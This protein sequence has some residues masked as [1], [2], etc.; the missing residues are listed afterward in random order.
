MFDKWLKLPAHYYLRITALVILTVGICLHNTL[1]SIGAIWIMANWLIEADYR[2]YWKK[3]KSTPTIWLLLGL[4]FL[5]LLSLLWSED[6]AYGLKD[7]GRKM[8]FF[9]I[10]F[11]LGLGKPVEKKVIFFLLYIFLGIVVLTSGINYYRYN[12]VLENV[13]DIRQMSYFISPIRFSVLTA[14][15]TFAA[16]YLIIKN[17]GPRI[18]WIAMIPWLLF[19]TFKAQM[20]NGYLMLAVLVI[21]TMIYLVKENSSYTW[22]WVIFSTFFF[23][24]VFGVWK[25]NSLVKLYYIEEDITLDDLELYTV[26]GNPYYHDLYTDVRENGNLV[27][28]YVQQEELSREWNERSEIPYDS[29]DRNGQPMYGT[30]MRYM[31]SKNLR[32]DSAGLAQLTPDEITKIENGATSIDIN[33][34]FRTKVFEVLYQWDMYQNGGDPNGHSLLQ[35]AEHMRVAWS[36]VKQHWL[37]GVGMGD[38]PT[39]FESEYSAT[40]SKLSEEY[41]HRSHNQYLTIWISHGFLGLICLVGMLLV[42]VFK[43]KHLDYFHGVVYLTLFFSLLFQDMIETQAGVTIFGLFYALATY[44]EDQSTNSVSKESSDSE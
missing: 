39:A 22:K 30:L 37:I 33:R 40:Q 15:G 17:K 32:K 10:P 43:R 29:L 1:M 12:Y 16:V 25:V 8:P 41:W 18:I 13:T 20:L 42:P 7:L 24:V 34:G 28:L 6:V 11:A 4:L 23:A 35:R 19:Y 44:Q 14:L 27:W 36:L 9:A 26:N 21:F 31:T 38:V 3:F 2:Y 5:G